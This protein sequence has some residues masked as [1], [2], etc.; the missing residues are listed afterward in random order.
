[1][2]NTATSN[3]PIFSFIGL[4]L[5]ISN[6]V[7]CQTPSNVETKKD[8]NNDTF[9]TIGSIER[10][11]AEINNLIPEG[12]E[13]EILAK[14]FDWSEGPVWISA[15]NALL[16]SDVPANTIYKWQKG[17]EAEVWLTPSGYTGTEE[18]GGETG[19]NGLILDAE[20]NLILCQH[21]D[22]RVA[23]LMSEWENPTSSFET[24]AETFEGKKFNSPNDAVYDKK[25]NL[26]FTDPP[27]GLEKQVDDPKKE[28]PFQGV[29]KVD[30]EGE[31][32]LFTD[33]LSR[34]N[35][36]ILSPD[37]NI[38][39]VANSDPEKAIWMAYELNEDGTMKEAQ[40]FFDVTNKVGKEKGLPDGMDIDENGNLFAT[41]P[42][43][44]YIFSPDRKH[45]GTIHTTQATSNCTFGNKGSTLYITADSLLLKVELSTIGSKYSM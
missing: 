34:P 42:G 36:I 21:G 20:G 8:N 6:L 1:M 14:G 31:V 33:E 25:G 22:R 26:Y 4:G 17:T 40:L 3:Y 18:R 45:L 2:K 24:I 7:S 28:I 27:Y 38:L 39:Y 15:L 19:S 44:V 10:I 29:F 37:E 23:K 32:H 43:G 13:I 16:F 35:G 41:G 9:E 12:T 11:E 5:L 30:T